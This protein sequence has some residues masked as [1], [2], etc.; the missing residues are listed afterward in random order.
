MIAPF[1]NFDRDDLFLSMMHIE[2]NIFITGADQKTIALDIAYNQGKPGPVIIYVHGF[3]GFKDWGNFDLVA[4]TFASSGFY[5]RNGIG[6]AHALY[7][8]NKN[9]NRFLC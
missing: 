5:N 3:N 8:A 2:K 1:H 7:A 4:K 9:R 6:Q